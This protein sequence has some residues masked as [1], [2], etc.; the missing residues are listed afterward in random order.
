MAAIFAAEGRRAVEK[1][2][3]IHDMEVMDNALRDEFLSFTFG[4]DVIDS[5]F[6]HG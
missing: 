4:T 6:W 1:R 3:R 2:V 5:F